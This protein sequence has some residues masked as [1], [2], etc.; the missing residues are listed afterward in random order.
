MSEKRA[1]GAFG[2]LRALILALTAIASVMLCFT[3]MHGLHSEQS[4]SAVSM[5]ATA[6]VGTTHAQAPHGDGLPNGNTACE[7]PCGSGHLMTA[8]QCAV[9]LIAPVLLVWITRSST[10]WA[11]IR[12][13]IQGLIQRART[14]TSPRPPSLLFLSISRT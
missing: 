8:T 9:A 4:A 12:R 10:A 13:R 1:R 11:P 6:P 5:A 7:A 2:V 14:T 3:V